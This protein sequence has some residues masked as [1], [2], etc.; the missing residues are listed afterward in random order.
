MWMIDGWMAGIDDLFIFLFYFFKLK[1][2][3]L[4]SFK[5]RWIL[6]GCQCFY[7]TSNCSKSDCI[8]IIRHCR[9]IHLHW[10]YSSA[11]VVGD[12]RLGSDQIRCCGENAAFPGCGDDFCLRL[13]RH[14]K[15]RLVQVFGG[16][17]PC[18][19]AAANHVSK[20]S[21]ANATHLTTCLDVTQWVLFGLITPELPPATQHWE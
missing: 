3:T 11:H 2:T 13:V 16:G 12:C 6:I 21:N 1:W 14:L 7:H 8:A 10:N 5:S 9:T 4:W 20:Q 15:L 17:A 18:P 19:A